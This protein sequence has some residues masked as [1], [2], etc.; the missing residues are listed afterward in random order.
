MQV[1]QPALILRGELCQVDE[2]AEK[3]IRMARRHSE[4]GARKLSHIPKRC[5]SLQ[6]SGPLDPSWRQIADERRESNKARPH[7]LLQ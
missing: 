4:R 1:R 6:V 5:C 2:A 7:S 3:F